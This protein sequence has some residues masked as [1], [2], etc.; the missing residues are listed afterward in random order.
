MAKV[1]KNGVYL[2]LLDDDIDITFQVNT[3]T[4]PTSKNAVYST[5]IM[6]PDTSHNVNVLGFTSLSVRNGVRLSKQKVINVILE[7]GSVQLLGYLQIT[8]FSEGVYTSSFFC[9]ISSFVNDISDK[10][11][12]DLNLD[13][14]KHTYTSYNI[15]AI[16]NEGWVYPFVNYGHWEITP[17][18][19]IGGNLHDYKHQYPAQSFYPAMFTHTVVKQ[20]FEDAGWVIDPKSE[21]I[22]DEAY[23]CEILPFSTGQFK[24][25][26]R[27]LTKSNQ[28][29]RHDQIITVAQ[30]GLDIP[31]EWENYLTSLPRNIENNQYITPQ[32]GYYTIRTDIYIGY[33]DISNNDIVSR[34]TF[35]YRFNIDGVSQGW[36]PME[37]YWTSSKMY[38]SSTF[39]VPKGKSISLDIKTSDTDF[40][41]SKIDVQT[42]VE[43]S[44]QTTPVYG[45]ELYPALFLPNMS[46]KDFLKDLFI[47]YGVLL[48]FS[49]TKKIVRMDLIRNIKLKKSINITDKIDY[50]KPIT[51]NYNKLSEPYG[52]SNFIRMEQPSDEDLF[53]QDTESIF[54]PKSNNLSNLNYT[55]HTLY[56]KINK[57]LQYGEGYFGVENDF[58]EGEKEFYKSPFSGT[59]NYKWF[60]ISGEVVDIP[61]IPYCKNRIEYNGSF[62]VGKIEP[63][64]NDLSSPRKMYTKEMMAIDLLYGEELNSSGFI[65]VINEK[66]RNNNADWWIASTLNYA[67]F[68]KPIFNKKID[69]SRY[70]LIYGKGIST[71]VS[72]WK[73]K[74]LHYSDNYY[75]RT[76]FTSSDFTKPTTLSVINPDDKGLIETNMNDLIDIV[77]ESIMIE[78]NILLNPE[79]LEYKVVTIDNSGF[80]G[81]YLIDSVVNF[82]G[83]EDSSVVNLIKI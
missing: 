44:K 68:E 73:T 14:Y 66:D 60:S 67:W 59:I 16:R 74:N 24:Y 11:L 55:P 76:A 42:Y 72:V 47:Q 58:L 22:S 49:F 17:N 33:V 29:L 50:S 69:E 35:S 30:S 79:I 19:Y 78:C 2:D 10:K 81:K 7:I 8:S 37:F 54:E 27:N 41:D 13:R 3:L 77:N 80:A 46:Q 39:F 23:N 53:K 52:K 4:D 15:C 36:F 51:V 31:I 75:G 25:D 6:I 28:H 70:N 12:R 20:I 48:D 82:K 65:H 5:D 26:E 61:F 1:S 38:N 45:D 21:L 40:D 34:L 57:V 32:D 62:V 9:A 18:L 43:L 63:E 71:S 64:Y 83:Y 56:N